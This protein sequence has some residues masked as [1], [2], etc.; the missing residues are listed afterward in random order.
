MNAVG[1]FA[2]R[3]VAQEVEGEFD[4]RAFAVDVILEE[5]I[6]LLVAQIYFGGEGDDDHAQVEG[7]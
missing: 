4:G 6:N 1:E 3:V 2:G 5:G 7:G